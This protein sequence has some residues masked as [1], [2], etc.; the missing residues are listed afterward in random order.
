MDD[1]FGNETGVDRRA[2]LAA[3]MAATVSAG[4]GIRAYEIGPG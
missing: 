2:V 3:A 4:R 1:R